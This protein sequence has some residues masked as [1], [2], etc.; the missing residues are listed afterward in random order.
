[1]PAGGPIDVDQEWARRSWR[2]M[3]VGGFEDPG[4]IQSASPWRK[5][6]FENP[7]SPEF[8]EILRIDDQAVDQAADR[9][10]R[11]RIDSLDG[12]DVHPVDGDGRAGG[13]SAG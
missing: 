10:H 3:M 4:D 9:R 13:P 5:S 8:K 11:G 2:M 1:M 7:I 6:H 12:G